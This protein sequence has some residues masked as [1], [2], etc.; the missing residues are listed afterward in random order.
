MRWVILLLVLAIMISSCAPPATVT[1]PSQLI[2]REEMPVETQPEET[3][4]AEKVMNCTEWARSLFP[5]Q[6]VFKQDVT[7]DPKLTREVLTMQEGRWKDGSFI[8][9]LS[10]TKI[11]VGS[12]KGENMAYY[13][14]RPIYVTVDQEK[15][16]YSYAEQ[17]INSQGVFLG[18]N[19]FKIRPVFRVH[20]DLT[21]EEKDASNT[22]I[23]MRY[24]TLLIVEPNILSCNKVS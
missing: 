21:K 19:T 13:Y 17:V 11:E 8:R 15:H 1:P 20:Y 2:P 14:T 12:Q 9:G 7:E 22:T 18:E 6:W 16:G 23:K 10:S 5:D 24:L 4:P 3:P